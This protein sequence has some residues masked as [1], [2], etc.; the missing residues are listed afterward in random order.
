MNSNPLRTPVRPLRKRPRPA[1]GPRRPAFVLAALS[2]IPLALTACGTGVTGGPDG[3]SAAEGAQETVNVTN[4]GREL[5]FD[6]TPANVVGMMPSQ[7]EMLIRLGLQDSLVGQA[8]TEV[9]ALPDDIADAAEDVP[10]LSTDAPPAREDLLAAGPDLV[11][12]PTEYEFTAEQGFASIDQLKENGAQAYVATGGCAERRNTAEVTDVVTD[13]GN[14]GA[15]MRVPDEAEK[16]SADAEE[17]LAA[18]E[19][20]IEGEE[21]PTVAQVFVEGESLTAIG[22]GVEAD[23]I[24]TAGG[25]NVFDPDAPE[26]EDFFAAEINPEEIISRDPEAIVFGVSGPDQAEK[27][28]EYIQSTFP[29]VAA[30]EN[31]TL[32]AVPQA[33]LHPGTLGNIDSVETIAEGLYPDAF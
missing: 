30:V 3:S 27:T 17:R 33:D 32:I 5:T 19:E 13:I 10:E 8:Q 20:A 28:R 12:S 26:F 22:A 24:A 11:V 15:I 7:T 1:A 9:S 18:V 23:I 25:E 2:A 6:A 29:D 16:L 21:R 31:D 14:L 4:C